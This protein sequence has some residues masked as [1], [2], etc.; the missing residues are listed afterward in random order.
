V[1]SSSP[2]ASG[3]L[4]APRRRQARQ[5][6]VQQLSS[7]SVLPG[8]YTSIGCKHSCLDSEPTVSHCKGVSGTGKGSMQSR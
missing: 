5:N 4:Q 6:F 7:S 3:V 8:A 2:N 1:S